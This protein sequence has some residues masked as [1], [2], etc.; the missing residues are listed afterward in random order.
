MP[1]FS[2]RDGEGLSV[3]QQDYLKA[4]YQL[5]EEEGTRANT[6]QL[7]SRLGVAAASVSEMLGKLAERRLISHERYQGAELTLAG[8]QL[9]VE[10]VRHHRL[11]ESYLVRMLGYG[12]DE[13]HE[14]ADRLEHAISEKL[15]ARIDC[16]LGAPQFDPHGDPIPTLDGEV[17]RLH[18]RP[19]SACL[20]GRLIV[21][22]V[23]DRD[24]EK[25]RVIGEFGLRPGTDIE[26][27]SSSRWQE[28][29]AL[30]V[31]Q[32]QHQLPL[33]LAEAVFVSEASIG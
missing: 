12:W 16:A 11:I 25:L 19:L 28:P 31:G 10:V 33:G 15:E 9:A 27:L 13:V 4:I 17:T 2:S 7:A 26:L 30:Q 6:S 1:K 23:S 20:P 8:R 14:E 5:V 24:S 18:L 21:N 32:S 22:R 3:A 29:L